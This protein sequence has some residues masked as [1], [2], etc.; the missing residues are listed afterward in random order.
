MYM[1]FLGIQVMNSAGDLALKSPE[2]FEL[3]LV[4]NIHNHIRMRRM[5]A[6]LSVVGFRRLAVKLINFLGVAIQMRY[7]GKLEASFTGTW[8]KYSNKDIKATLK[9]CGIDDPAIFES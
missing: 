5:M 1:H 3:A 9:N 6:C 2:R 4:K 7:P 8:G